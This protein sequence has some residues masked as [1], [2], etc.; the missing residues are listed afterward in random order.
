MPWTL[1]QIFRDFSRRNQISSKFNVFYE[2]KRKVLCVQSTLSSWLECSS[3]NFFH[4]WLLFSSS[5]SL[6]LP[7]WHARNE[8]QIK[9]TKCFSD[10]TIRLSLFHSFLIRIS[11]LRM[12][13]RIEN[14][15]RPPAIKK[16]DIGSIVKIKTIFFFFATRDF[17][18]RV[19]NLI[20]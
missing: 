6:S 19:Y 1:Q 12:M 9:I 4:L 3:W 17:H 10:S 14:S 20:I 15:R 18:G 13:S 5:S 7:L 2:F 8:N 11:L 16:E